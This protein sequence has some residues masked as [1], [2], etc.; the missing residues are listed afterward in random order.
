M[1]FFSSLRS[2]IFLTSAMLTVLSIGAAIYVV[3]VRVT[4]QAESALQREIVATGTLVDQLR[5]TRTET[6]T[7]LARLIGDIPK[8]KSAAF[9]NDPQTVQR[10]IEDIQRD[11]K[12]SSNLLLVTNKSGG[13]LAVF[14]ASPHAGGRRRP[15]AGDSRRAGRPRKHEPAAAAQRHAAAGHRADCHRAHPPRNPRHAERRL[16]PRRRGRRAVESDDRQRRRVR[17]GWTGP[18]DHPAARAAGRPGFAAPSAGPRPRSADRR[19]GLRGAGP[20]AHRHRRRSLAGHRPGGADPPLAHRATGRSAGHPCRPD[21]D[22]DRGGGR[23]ARCSASRSRAPS[24]GPWRRSPASC[25]KWPRPAT[26]RARS[27]CFEAT[28]GT[29]KTHGC[30]PRHSTR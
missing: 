1:M 18:D 5:T 10:T 6:F 15:A 25:A 24:R 14:G 26:S 28:G 21:R 8:L 30:W 3:N 29:T 13:V 12:L 17:R 2:R 11:L 16:P 4:R 20:A 27:R 9:E 23:S 7:T 19:R 22:G